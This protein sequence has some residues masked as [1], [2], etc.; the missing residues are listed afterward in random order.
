MINS[1]YYDIPIQTKERVGFP[2]NYLSL[3]TD[4]QDFVDALFRAS[5]SNWN[6]LEDLT[7]IKDEM[8]IV[9][10]RLND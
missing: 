9:I 5:R 10:E 1:A 4:Q 7:S 3:T 6:L 8:E 2:I